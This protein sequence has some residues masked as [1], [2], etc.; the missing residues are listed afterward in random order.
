MIWGLVEDGDVFEVGDEM[1][2]D[3][4]YEWQ[5]VPTQWVGLNVVHDESTTF[6]RFHILVRRRLLELRPNDAQQ[7]K[8]AICQTCNGSGIR[9]RGYP[10]RPFKCNVCGGSGKQQ[11]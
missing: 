7:A 9:D 5:P 3:M 11:S 4:K 1:W 10:N 2:S 6:G 8:A